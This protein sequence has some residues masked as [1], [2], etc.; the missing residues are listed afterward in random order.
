NAGVFPL[1]S[2][3][4]AS[5][6]HTAE[7]VGWKLANVR[8]SVGQELRE[9]VDAAGVKHNLIENEQDPVAWVSLVYSVWASDLADHYR[10]GAQVEVH[11]S[12]ELEGAG[13]SAEEASG[14]N[15][16]DVP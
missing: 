10:H 7:V 2:G 15:G 1:G 5:N 11:P 13:M 14:H 3:G 4:I 16:R 12:D 9:F 6:G 8:G